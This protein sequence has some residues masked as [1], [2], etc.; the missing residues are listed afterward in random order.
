MSQLLKDF[1]KSEINEG[2]QNTRNAT[3]ARLINWANVIILFGV[4]V[5]ITDNKW[6]TMIGRRMDSTPAP[7]LLYFPYDTSKDIVT[8]PNY[9]RRWANQY[10]NFLKERMHIKKDIESLKQQICVGINKD[11]LKLVD[12]M[13]E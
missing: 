12:N 11:F 4:S 13:K 2:C 9:K 8:F 1:I 5:G 10:I 6:W 3:F 7:L